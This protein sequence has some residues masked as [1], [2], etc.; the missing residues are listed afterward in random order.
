LTEFEAALQ[1]D[2]GYTPF[3][4]FLQSHGITITEIKHTLKN[5]LQWAKP[6]PVN[7]PI[8]V[9]VSESYVRPEPLGVALVISVW[10]YPYLAL[11]FAATVIAVGNS[12]VLKPSEFAAATSHFIKKLFN[13]Y[14]DQRFYRYVE[15]KSEVARALTNSKFDLIRFT[16]SSKTGV[17][18]AQAVAKNLVPCVLE[19]GGKCSVVVDKTADLVGAAMRIAQG[20]FMNSGQVCV[21]GDHLYVDNSVKK[22]FLEHL[23]EQTK[24]LFGDDPQDTGDM[25]KIVSAE[26]VKRLEGYLKEKHWGKVLCGGKVF[27]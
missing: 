7:T 10:N 24:A 8:L 20:R 9:G 3:T 19:L 14:L 23:V 25:G 26:H 15:G 17:L 5:F 18:V 12:V 6:V 2:L 21:A 22:Q 11:P 16:G 4:S 27:P 1:Q 13:K